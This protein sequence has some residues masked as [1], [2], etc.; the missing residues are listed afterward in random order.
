M[1]YGMLRPARPI[2]RPKLGLMLALVVYGACAVVTSASSLSDSDAQ[3]T[4]QLY[5]N[6]KYRCH[7]P[8]TA[9]KANAPRLHASLFG[10]GRVSH[11][12]HHAPASDVQQRRH[13]SADVED[14]ACR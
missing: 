9:H 10:A 12:G 7:A 8:A 13:R 2:G 11:C 5:G 3:P 1:L 14:S 6:Q 4:E